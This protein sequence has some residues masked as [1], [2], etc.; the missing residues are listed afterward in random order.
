MKTTRPKI[1]VWSLTASTGIVPMPTIVTVAVAVA[2]VS[3]VK[4][5]NVSRSPTSSSARVATVS[6]TNT[7]SG[8]RRVGQAAGAHHGTF[9]REGVVGGGE[10]CPCD[11]W[12]DAVGDTTE[13]GVDLLARDPRH[14]VERLL[15]LFER[16]AVGDGGIRRVRSD[17]D[18]LVCRRRPAR[19]GEAGETDAEPETEEEPGRR[20][21]APP[22]GQPPARDHRDGAHQPPL[23]P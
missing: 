6:L 9:E 5:W 10:Q 21:A 3:G 20:H 23:R 17:E 7:S 22:S 8:R 12:V 16:P 13:T 15:G 11:G 1:D 18:A 19:R 4:K 2:G 14:G